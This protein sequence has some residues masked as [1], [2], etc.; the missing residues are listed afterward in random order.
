MIAVHAG[1]ATIRHVLAVE[2]SKSHFAC[3]LTTIGCGRGFWEVAKQGSVD[4]FESDFAVQ[5]PSFPGF[6]Q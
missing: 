4:F 5:H 6:L 3:H 2:V 1:L